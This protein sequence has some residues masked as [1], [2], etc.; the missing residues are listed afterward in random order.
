MSALV[1]LTGRRFGRL[2]VVERAA[3]S[4]AVK[5]RCR[6]D[7]GAIKDFWATH[8]RRGNSGSCG[9]VVRLHGAS[10]S[11][12]YASWKSMR[13][14]CQRPAHKHFKDYGGRGISVCDRWLDF[15]SFLADMG[16]RPPGTSLDRIDNDGNYEPGNCRWATARQQRGHTRA[17]RTITFG[18]ETRIVA[19]WSRLLGIPRSTILSR[20]ARGESEAECLRGGAHER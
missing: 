20:L 11:R 1:D 6:C 8:L 10:G 15:R 3:S 12:T 16:P 13:D 17:N 7:C 19:E 4:G 9:C 2:V 18:G 5:W 14:R